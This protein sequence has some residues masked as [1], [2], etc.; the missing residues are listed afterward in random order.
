MLRII[1]NIKN[2]SRPNRYLTNMHMNINRYFTQ[3]KQP[4]SSNENIIFSIPKE[5]INNIQ[6]DMLLDRVCSL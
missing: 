4:D 5:K 3:Q 1:S 6:Y 2:I